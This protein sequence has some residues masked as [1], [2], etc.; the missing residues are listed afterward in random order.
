MGW[1]SDAAAE[2]GTPFGLAR[3]AFAQ[4]DC[5]HD[6]SVRGATHNLDSWARTGVILHRSRGASGHTRHDGPV[7]AFRHLNLVA[8][9]RTYQ[10]LV[11]WRLASRTGQAP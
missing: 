1:V 2:R 9:A 6:P 4:R 10:T 3:S 8:T 7:T 11:L 5:G